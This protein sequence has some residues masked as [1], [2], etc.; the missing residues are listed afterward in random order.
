[1]PYVIYAD[2]ESIIKPCHESKSAKQ[3]LRGEHIACGFALQIFRYDGQSEKKINSYRHSCAMNIFF[4][5]LQEAA[6][7]IYK[8]YEKTCKIY[9]HTPIAKQFANATTC[10]I[11]ECY[12]GGKNRKY[13][14]Y[15]TLT[16]KY[17]SAACAK[18]LKQVR[19][20]RAT[21]IPIFI[22]NFR[23]YD[24]HLIMQNIHEAKGRI[25]CISNNTE[26]YI[27]LSEGQLV[28][29]DTFQFMAASLSKLV[30]GCT[31]FDG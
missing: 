5:C 16:G 23:G 29:K 12:F 9:P 1:M 27:S 4:H 21:K 18:C 3:T 14:D 6:F 22:H 31:D 2:F 11:C 15:C 20:T 28:F 13:V 17:R 25:T 7:W 26:K 10:W 24:S 19:P 8:M 30:A